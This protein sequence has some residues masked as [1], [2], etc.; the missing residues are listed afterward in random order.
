MP[1]GEDTHI[2][3][4]KLSN[5]YDFCRAKIKRQIETGEIEIDETTA[6]N[7]AWLAGKIM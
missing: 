1:D 2:E 3:Q 7:L 6:G 4:D 5:E